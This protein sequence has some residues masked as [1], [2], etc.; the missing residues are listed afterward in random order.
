MSVSR[1][2]TITA[3]G[4]TQHPVG[5]KEQVMRNFNATINELDLEKKKPKGGINLATVIYIPRD[6]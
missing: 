1:Y 4:D 3:F 6:Q 5:H 2:V